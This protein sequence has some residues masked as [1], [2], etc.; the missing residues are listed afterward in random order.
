MKKL[1][2]VLL[3]FSGTLLHSQKH[4]NNWQVCNSIDSDPPIKYWFL[5][6][7]N[8]PPSLVKYFSP[9]R[10]SRANLV[11]SDAMGGVLF[12]SNGFQVSDG[13]HNIM[14][15]GDSINKGIFWSESGLPQ[16]LSL[17]SLPDPINEDKYYIIYCHYDTSSFS[18]VTLKK[19]LYSTID[20]TLNNG[21]GS[22]LSI[23]ST[24]VSGDYLSYPSAVRHGN[25]SDWW[26][27]TPE[28]LDNKYYIQL[29]SSD[30]FSDPIIQEIGPIPELFPQ[31][32]GN[33]LFTPDGRKYTNFDSDDGLRIFDFDRCTGLLSNIKTCV[34]PLL[35]WGGA[36]ISPNSRF[37]YTTH[38]YYIFQYDLDASDV[39]ASIDTV[40]YTTD[41]ELIGF[42]VLAPD[43]KIYIQSYDV[44]HKLHIIHQPDLKG[45]LCQVELN[46]F[47]IPC[48]N[49]NDIPTFPNYRLYD[50]PGSPCDTLGINDPNV[51]T[52]E[53]EAD[54]QKV[55]L[56]P[57]PATDMLYL[58]LLGYTK[59]EVRYNITDPAGRKVAEGV[60]PVF[61]EQVSVVVKY[62]PEG[63]YF[64]SI[65]EDGTGMRSLKF[66]KSSG[67]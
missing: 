38:G 60:S 39:C 65:M 35:A 67:E 22:V 32:L 23:D 24:I 51:A 45:D 29:L 18:P 13:S 11:M 26:I 66:V 34:S 43:G 2:I 40:L 14:M 61:R 41:A 12:Y 16:I 3:C 52:T 9:I 64:I 46:A 7:N 56:Y 42:P 44:S 47:E 8:S 33:K 17:I 5:N 15:N 6:F 53:V 20:L 62:L 50:L 25:G 54:A 1:L 58:S 21:F 48:N 59:S 57:N 28:W 49:L 4:D 55:I 30:G 37:L 27:I 19:I 31:A 63:M 10:F 36:A